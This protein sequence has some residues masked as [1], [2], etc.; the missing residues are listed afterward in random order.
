M[1]SLIIYYARPVDQCY[2]NWCPSEQWM[3]IGYCCQN[4]IYFL[5]L[6][7]SKTD[8]IKQS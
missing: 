3:L 5:W 7:K 6:N 4:Y 2:L 8:E 1:G